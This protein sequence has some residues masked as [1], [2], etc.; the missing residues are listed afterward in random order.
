[1]V[2]KGT[3]LVELDDHSL[4]AAELTIATAEY[5]VHNIRQ[6]LETAILSE[7]QGLHTILSS[8][9]NRAEAMANTLLK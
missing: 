6:Q 3:T 2:Q 7:A 5:R 9:W 8:D 1:M 4:A